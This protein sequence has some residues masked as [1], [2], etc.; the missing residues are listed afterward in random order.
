MRIAI[1]SK[2]KLSKVH[3]WRIILLL[4]NRLIARQELTWNQRQGELIFSNSSYRIARL[5][6][7]LFISHF[8]NAFKK[9][10]RLREKCLILILVRLDYNEERVVICRDGLCHLVNTDDFIQVDQNQ[11]SR[12][13]AFTVSAAGGVQSKGKVINM[14]SFQPS[15]HQSE[16][17]HLTGMIIFTI[18]KCDPTFYNSDPC[19]P[20][21][22]L[23]LVFHESTSQWRTYCQKSIVKCGPIFWVHLC[24]KTC[25]PR[26]K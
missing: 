22:S 26:F 10:V 14:N 12:L 4:T 17:G 13:R 23:L 24:A 21:I 5:F 9:E 25:M 16:N 2:T 3:L 18:S 11:E 1:S 8:V 15:F 19:G 7:C 6:W 20:P